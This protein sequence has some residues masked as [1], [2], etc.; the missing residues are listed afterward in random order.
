MSH[1]G[2]AGQKLTDMKAGRVYII[3]DRGTAR[4]GAIGADGDDWK[5]GYAFIAAVDG[6]E[7]NMDKITG[8][9][10]AWELNSGYP[11]IR[12]QANGSYS[13]T[14][15]PLNLQLADA[16]YTEANAGNAESAEFVYANSAFGTDTK[17]NNVERIVDY[18]GP[19]DMTFP[20]EGAWT[21]W[22]TANYSLFIIRVFDGPESDLFGDFAILRVRV[23][24]DDRTIPFAQ[25]YDINPKTEGQ[26]RQNIP[27]TNG[28]NDLAK[29]KSRSLSPM[30]IGE[31]AGS[32]RTK[33]GLW[34]TA[35]AL[36]SVDKPGHIEPRVMGTGYTT[37]PYT[38]VVM[39]YNGTQV[40]QQHSLSSAQMGGAPTLAD[41]SVTVPFADPRGFFTADTV[42]GEVVLRG[43]AEDDQRVQRV[44]LVIGS[45]TV[46]I[47]NYPAN[48]APA[49]GTGSVAATEGDSA[50]YV[51]PKTGL[52]TVPQA[53]SGNVY[54]TDTIDAYRHRV[55]WAYI[56][57]TERVPASTMVGPVTVRAV[58][59]IRD[60]A[61]GSGVKNTFSGGITNDE[62]TN[63]ATSLTTAAPGAPHVST[64]E[65]KPASETDSKYRKYL[66]ES[67]RPNTRPFNKDFQVGLYKYNSI[68]FNLRPYITGFLRREDQFSHNT[69]SRQGRYMFYR[70]EYAVVKGFNLGG[71]GST[72]PTISINGTNINAV[73]VGSVNGGPTAANFGITTA[74]NSRYRQFQVG[75]GVTT[76]S[77]MVVY[78]FNSQNAVNTGNGEAYTGSDR[79][80]ITAGTATVPIRPTYIQPWNVEYSAN[81]DGSTLWDDFTQAHIWQSNANNNG[82]ST[83][84]VDNGI[85]RNGGAN[86]EVFDPAMSIDPETGILWSSHNE[87]GGNGGNSGSTK[88]SNNN[89][90]DA[91]VVAAFID[92]IIN[93]DIYI[94]YRNS[95]FSGSNLTNSVWT[96][97][98]IIGKPG[99][100]L[101][102]R[103]F[104]GIWLNGP[105]GGRVNHQFGAD[106]SDNNVRDNYGFNATGSIASRGQYH[107][108]ST[109][110]NSYPTGNTT[111]PDSG[112]ALNQFKNPHIITYAPSDTVEHIHVSYY[113]T[114]DMSIKYR[115]NRRGEPG[116]VTGSGNNGSSTGL[117]NIPRGWTNLDGKFDLEDQNGAS[118]AANWFG[119]AT[120]SSNRIVNTSRPAIDAGE[121]NSIAVTSDGYP[122]VAYYDNT[123]Q[124][125]KLAVSNNTAPIAGSNWKIIDNIIPAAFKGTGQYV[126]MRIDTRTGTNQNRIHIAAMNS[127]NKSLV[128]ISGFANFNSGTNAATFTGNSDGTGAPVVQVVDSVG[129]VGRW[130]A[131][132][133]DSDGNP[134]ISY[135][136]ESYQ[137][138]RDGIKLAYRNAARYYKGTNVKSQTFYPYQPDQDNDI[139]NVSITG[140]E[141][142]H[143]PTRFR[144]DNARSGMEC[145]PTRN[146][147]GTR[148]VASRDW[149]G[150][151]GYLGENYF[152]AAYYIE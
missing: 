24:N 23:N 22:T 73:N 4:W 44:D 76:G 86:M 38:N 108:E 115:Y 14:G 56:W 26:D 29:E 66:I 96:A 57:D 137:G 88:V 98:S 62:G 121:Y 92:P 138:S 111:L 75:T 97:S 91:F 16:T 135:Q 67:T 142:M 118:Q 42:S 141:A 64:V 55:E 83:N 1:D 45:E 94:S 99:G 131:I 52:L 10:S 53:Q 84:G 149:R 107:G 70:E 123:N 85:F 78:T 122:V 114:K 150:A 37:A 132:S 95:G 77:G 152:R 2:P 144:V 120:G 113:D 58:A 128:Y 69:R 46:T 143:V 103:Y 100:G 8:T 63:T 89:G 116:T 41:A 125:L 40:R 134:W 47:L 32:N 79:R 7:N 109:F 25:L 148:T 72:T 124:R 39:T 74:S 110:Y 11:A 27:Q 146:F 81:V 13:Q 80:K 104:G 5:R 15:I 140:W 36:G 49:A 65:P 43:Y 30:F 31:G 151:V 6:R 20:P 35:S 127:M 3:N 87:G 12:Q 90:A 145:Y 105:G 82:G 34:N 68:S 93:S 136:D 106:F 60:T 147:T 129:S 19:V 133:L 18:N 9:G 48:P 59:Y 54:F 112:P 61:T 71:V 28:N 51:S 102:W 117:T 119:V 101:E 139:T 126:S 21:T 50:N 33:G 17:T 130:C